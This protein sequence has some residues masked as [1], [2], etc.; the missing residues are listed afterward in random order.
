MFL[1]I[2]MLMALMHSSGNLFQS[3][4]TLWEDVVF[5]CANLDCRLLNHVFLIQFVAQLIYL[6]LPAKKASCTS[7][8]IGGNHRDKYVITRRSKDAA[9]AAL[10]ETQRLVTHMSRHSSVFPQPKTAALQPPL[11]NHPLSTQCSVLSRL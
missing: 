5:L 4:S 10:D 11:A 7:N 3:F 6:C 9:V 2:F 8:G 1:N